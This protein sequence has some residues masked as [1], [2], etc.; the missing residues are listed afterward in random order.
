MKCVGNETDT[1]RLAQALSWVAPELY[2]QFLANFDARFTLV[3]KD[4]KKVINVGD[5]LDHGGMKFSKADVLPSQLVAVYGTL[6]HGFGNNYLLKRG[7]AKFWGGG[8][9]V[10]KHRMP[11]WQTPVVFKGTNAKGEGAAI[12]VEVYEVTTGLLEGDLDHLEGHPHWYKRE[13]VKVFL[14]FGNRVETCWLYF[15]RENGGDRWWG[16]DTGGPYYSEYGVRPRVGYGTGMVK[17]A[18][19][20]SFTAQVEEEDPAQLSILDD[21][22]MLASEVERVREILRDGG[23]DGDNWEDE[24]IEALIAGG[25][26]KRPQH[27]C[28]RC[29]EEMEVDDNWVWCDM[30]GHYEHISRHDRTALAD[31]VSGL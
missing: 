13:K 1:A 14:T 20:G 18:P 8:F 3:H 30:C 17:S 21:P 22:D 24:D 4:T 19:V 5:F 23:L 10:D 29:G 25:F 31:R 28:R 27:P 26:A 9:T 7:G 16:T 15:M 11:D 6:K 2:P 12:K